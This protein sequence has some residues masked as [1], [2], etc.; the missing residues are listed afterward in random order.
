L[1]MIE[2]STQTPTRD[3]EAHAGVSGPLHT[4]GEL[5]IRGGQCL[6]G[7]RSVRFVSR[8]CGL[9]QRTGLVS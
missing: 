5:K 7:R 3:A 1:L 4:I 9:L 8:T 2:L 6:S